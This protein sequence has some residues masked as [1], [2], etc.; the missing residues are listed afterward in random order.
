MFHFYQ[1]KMNPPPKKRKKTEP[2]KIRDFQI[3]EKCI[4]FASLPVGREILSL[5][6]GLRTN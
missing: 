6:F 5:S 3:K 4:Y 2:R 1:Q